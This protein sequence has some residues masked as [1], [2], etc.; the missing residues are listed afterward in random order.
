MEPTNENLDDILKKFLV[1]IPE[2][3][4]TAIVSS[5]GIPVASVIPQ[6]VD[7]ERITP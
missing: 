1:A 7:K 5:E 6:G 4:A 2:V 3:K